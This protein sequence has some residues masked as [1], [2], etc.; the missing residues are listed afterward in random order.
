MPA[1]ALQ[2]PVTVQP[3]P[4]TLHLSPQGIL[5]LGLHL[6][7]SGTGDGRPQARLAIRQALTQALASLLQRPPTDIH[8]DNQRGQP[9]QIRIAAS[10][11][12]A[13]HCSFAYSDGYAVAAVNL[14]GPIGVDL[15]PVLEIPDWTAL[16]RDYLGPPTLARLQAVPAS[17][18]ALALAQAWCRLEAGYKCRAEALT[19]W[20]GERPD[21]ALH[22]QLILPPLPQ[23]PSQLVGH[24][25]WHQ[26]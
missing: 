14:H 17:Q 1:P 6:P 19:E 11:T 21:H 15:T 3:W 20:T 25:S 13:P 12:P 10:T 26:R 24:V 7:H 2:P 16:A 4:G 23:P 22:A 8:I 18:R 9:A 5:V